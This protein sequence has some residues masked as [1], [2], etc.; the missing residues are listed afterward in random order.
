MGVIS[1]KVIGWAVCSSVLLLKETNKV[2]YH[3]CGLHRAQRLELIGPQCGSL[4]SECLGLRGLEIC[5]VLGVAA[6]AR[7]EEGF[8][9]W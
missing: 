5:D 4:N 8:G 1:T 6:I 3:S 2:G 7:V 9:K